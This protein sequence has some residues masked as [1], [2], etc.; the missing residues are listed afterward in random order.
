MELSR[1]PWNCFFNFVWPMLFLIHVKAFHGKPR[2][3]VIADYRYL[4]FRF[5]FQI[6]DESCHLRFAD[7]FLCDFRQVSIYKL[8]WEDEIEYKLKLTLLS[9]MNLLQHLGIVHSLSI[10]KTICDLN[11]AVQCDEFSIYNFAFFFSAPKRSSMELSMMVSSTSDIHL[12]MPATIGW[13]QPLW[14]AVETGTASSFCSSTQTVL[15]MVFTTTGS[16]KGLPLK[17]PVPMLLRTGWIQ[18]LLWALE[19]GMSSSFC[20]LILKGYCMVLPMASFTGE[21]PLHMAQTTGWDLLHWLE[22]A[23]GKYSSSCSSTQWECCMALKTAGF[24]R[25]SRPRMQETTGWDQQ[26]LLVLEDGTISSCFSSWMTASCMAS[27]TTSSTSVH[28]LSV[29]TITGWALQN[30]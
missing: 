9:A 17:L 11:L 24:T 19:D 28:L 13:D 15:Y 22:V 25:E 4:C 18:R 20:F 21:P 26:L 30:W 10:F 7:H 2:D 14:S 27:T 6:S 16:T 3:L 12:N 5:S 1:N 29:G 23:A 8:N